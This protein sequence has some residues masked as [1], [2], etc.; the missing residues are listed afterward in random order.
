MSRLPLIFLAA[1]AACLVVGVGLGLYMG[2]VHDFQLAPVHA[3]T[4]LVGWTSLGLMGLAMRAW[5]ELATGRLAAIQGAV[6]ISS[7]AL[8][9]AGIYLAI[10]QEAPLLAILAGIGW[11]AGT[12]LFLG[13][14]LRLALSAQGH[15]RPVMLPAE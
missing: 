3:H 7:A 11:F 13:R 14:V 6:S 15:G 10:T 8:F 2:I 1:A 5:P 12:L 9:P 4:N